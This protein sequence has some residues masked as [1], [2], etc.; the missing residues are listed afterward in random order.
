MINRLL[1]ITGMISGLFVLVACS[2]YA[3]DATRRADTINRASFTENGEVRLPIG[4][5]T[6]THVGTRIETSG[7]NILDGQE[8]KQPEMLNAYIEPSALSH[9]R[10]TGEWPDGALTVKDFTTVRA[11]EG[12]DPVSFVCNSK[13]GPAIFE[14]GHSLVSK[15]KLIIY[16][17]ARRLPNSIGVPT[18]IHLGMVN[19]NN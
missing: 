16:L 1:V 11:G 2:I 5:R 8:I 3:D 10:K 6:W 4:Y 17:D 15:Y 9:F 19:A 14:D 7:V 18:R 12:C 13:I